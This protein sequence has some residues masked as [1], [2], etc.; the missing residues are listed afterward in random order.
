MFPRS[1]GFHLSSKRSEGAKHASGISWESGLYMLYVTSASVM[2]R[3]VF[4]VVEY[5][6]G[7]DGYLFSTE[8][9]VYVFDAALMT[10]TMARFFWRYRS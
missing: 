6:M 3:N 2:A 7:R 9:P 10:V 8:W 5:A 4:R 1:R